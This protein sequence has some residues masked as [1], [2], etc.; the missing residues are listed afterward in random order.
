MVDFSSD[1]G[2]RARQRLE[3]EPIGWFVTVGGDGTPQP[4]PIWFLWDGDTILLYSQP[5][6]PKVRNVQRHPQTALHLEGDGEG[7]NIV[8]LTGTAAVEEAAPVH[9]NAPYLEKY[10]DWIAR[11]GMTPESMAAAYSTAIRF[12]PAALRGN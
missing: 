11:I 10:R 1:F 8:I 9:Q 12:R 7:G 5:N 2:K 4:S 6:A 3:Q